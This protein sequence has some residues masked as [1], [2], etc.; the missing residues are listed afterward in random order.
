MCFKN[1]KMYLNLT[2]VFAKFQTIWHK[3]YDHLNK[4]IFVSIQRLKV[5]LVG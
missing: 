5:L 1:F 3:V 2:I 4:A